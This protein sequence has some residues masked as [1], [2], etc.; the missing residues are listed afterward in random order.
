MSSQ[1]WRP[2]ETDPVKRLTQRVKDLEALVGRLMNG[3]LT[4]AGLAVAEDVLAV[5]GSLNV[6]GELVV[7]GDTHIEGDLE[8]PNGAIKNEYLENP[9]EV[10]AGAANADGF[11]VSP[12][13][14]IFA[15]FTIPIPS[16]YTRALVKAEGMAFAYNSTTAQDYFYE[17]VYVNSPTQSTW[18]RRLL[19]DL[20]GQAGAS[21]TVTK[22]TV[23]ENLTGGVLTVELEL[24]T[25]FA[26]ITHDSNGATVTASAWFLR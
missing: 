24:K 17:R 20:P 8:V 5:G 23:F 18:S 6:S 4:N 7:T 3:T 16:G 25:A 13:E 2:Q 12:T 15:A 19:G 14:S 26:P 22:Q 21:L 1:E 11:T 9:I 10:G